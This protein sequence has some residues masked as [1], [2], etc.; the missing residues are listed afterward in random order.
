M[1]IQVGVAS[2]PKS[3]NSMV[4]RVEASAEADPSAHPLLFVLFE[5]RR[6]GL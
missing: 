5:H 1:G 6:V 4:W 3:T 2:A